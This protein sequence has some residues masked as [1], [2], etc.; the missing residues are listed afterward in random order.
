[1]TAPFPRFGRRAEEGPAA[2]AGVPLAPNAEFSHTPT[3]LSVQF[4]DLSTDLDGTIV[5]WHWDFGDGPTRPTADFSII[6]NG[7]SVT[8]TDLSTDVPPGTIASWVWNFG[9]GTTSTAQNPTHTYVAGGTYNVSLT[10]TDNEGNQSTLTKTA[11]AS[12]I[13]TGFGRPLGC[14]NAWSSI[15]SLKA[16]ILPHL[17]L[18]GGDITAGNIIARIDAC[19]R[20]GVKMVWQPTGGSHTKYLTDGKFDINKWRSERV[21]AYAALSASNKAI[22][23]QAIADGIIPGASLVDE[24]DHSSWGGV[25][26]KRVTGEPGTVSVTQL[27]SEWKAIFPTCPTG[28]LSQV[29]WRSFEPWGTPYDFNVYQYSARRGSVTAYRDS[30]IANAAFVE[31][32]NPV[33][34]VFSMNILNGGERIEG[35]PEPQTGG[36]GVGPTAP[37]NCRMSD[38]NLVAFGPVLLSG[39]A[40][41]WMWEAREDYLLRD[42]DLVDTQAAMSQLASLAATLS[43]PTW[44]RS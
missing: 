28:V 25:F 7:L 24:P 23:N 16:G 37:P 39:G 18:T 6:V 19:R 1:M 38:E 9:D 44:R 17:K 12:V 29:T 21:N 33:V 5:G 10:V 30:C 36:L 15:T 13:V 11:Q 42:D 35:C 34:V 26:R 4:N 40:G 14:Q 27:V 41:L 31:S 3:G 32:G 20:L 2:A 8:F 22:I 43:K